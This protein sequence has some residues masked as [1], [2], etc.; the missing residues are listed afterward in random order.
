MLGSA[1]IN[2]FH[3]F[4]LLL[5]FLIL[6]GSVQAADESQFRCTVIEALDRLPPLSTE[7]SS[8][9]SCERSLLDRNL[10]P[11][12]STF[13]SL[14]RPSVQNLMNR[15]TMLGGR[16]EWVEAEGGSLW[17]TLDLDSARQIFVVKVSHAFRN[18]PSELPV[19]SFISHEIQ[20]WIDLKEIGEMLSSKFAI[21]ESE[22]AEKL[23]NLLG[24]RRT[25]MSAKLH[26]VLEKR[27]LESEHL[28]GI[29]S[30][31]TLISTDPSVSQQREYTLE[32]P[33]YIHSYP[34]IQAIRFLI[35]SDAVNATLD[36]ALEPMAE[37][38]ADIAIHEL[39]EL[40]RIL[41]RAEADSVKA[42]PPDRLHAARESAKRNFRR[43]FTDEAIVQNMHKSFNGIFPEI[44]KKIFFPML[45]KRFKAN[46]SRYLDLKEGTFFDSLF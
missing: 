19:N 9:Q 41:I 33:R 35:S 44:Q 7:F 23:F 11:E 37:Y 8:G 27:A 46:E 20:H 18:P 36:P 40:Y 21:T 31:M 28:H 45:L 3:S 39:M 29:R 2:R 10:P 4:F 38:Y 15:F 22:A 34:A 42:G 25:E 30:P 24:S 5:S 17:G 14:M 16:L 26:Y 13:N 32:F 43:L 12:A 6:D 1:Y